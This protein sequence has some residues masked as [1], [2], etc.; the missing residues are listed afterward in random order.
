MPCSI[1]T[2]ISST[3]IWAVPSRSATPSG[4]PATRT[5]S[6]ERTAASGS[7]QARAVFPAYREMWTW[8][9]DMW[10]TLPRS[11]PQGLTTLT[12]VLPHLRLR[13]PPSPD[14]ITYVI[15]P[16]DTLSGIAQ[17]YG[18]TVSALSSL[19]GI[20]N[21]DLIYAGNTIRVPENGGSGGSGAQ[22]Y[23]IRPGDT[24]SGIAVKFGTTVNAL[25]ALNGISNPDLIYAGNTIRVR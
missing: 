24:L 7:T 15:Q 9:S 5:A 3:P 6:T 17:R 21:P 8:I 2:A 4:T 16:G 10:I 20:S 18:T 11:K 13:R 1:Q 14:Y 19:N 22:Y 23:T 12:A 25:S